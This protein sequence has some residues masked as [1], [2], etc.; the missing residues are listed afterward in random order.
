MTRRTTYNG[1]VSIIRFRLATVKVVVCIL[2]RF[3]EGLARCIFLASG[4]FYRDYA[5]ARVVMTCLILVISGF[6][7]TK[8]PFLLGNF[9]FVSRKHALRFRRRTTI[10]IS[11]PGKRVTIRIGKRL[12]IYGLGLFFVLRTRLF[13]SFLGVRETIGP[14]AKMFFT[15]L[16]VQFYVIW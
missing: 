5:I 14:D 8:G 15:A 10:N 9:R 4:M 16:A 3:I 6:L 13:F 1:W 2:L 11:F 12:V 7:R